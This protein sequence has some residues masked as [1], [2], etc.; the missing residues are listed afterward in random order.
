MADTNLVTTDDLTAL[1]VDFVNNF[2]TSIQDLMNVLSGV[3]PQAMPQGAQI[4]VYKKAVTKPT[5]RT[6]GEGEKINN[7]DASYKVDKTYTLAITDKLRK[8]TTFEAIQLAG[9]QRAIHDTDALVINQAQNNA[10][11]DLYDALDSKANSTASGATFQA[12]VANALGKL[13]S[14][15]G[16]HFGGGDIVVFANPVD[17][18]AWLGNQTIS[19]Q[20]TFGLQ[21]VKN[22]LGA[23]T[24]IMSPSVKA[25]HVYATYVKNIHFYYIDMNGQAGQLFHATTDASGLIGIMHDEDTSNLTYNTTAVGGWLIL[26]E[27]AEYIV[28]STI[29]ATASQ[30]VTTGTGK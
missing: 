13:I 26:P 30:P 23:N 19:V 7:I 9:A 15:A 1:S 25:G 27:F 16:D 18:Y 28:N 17:V 4:K 6:V 12:A 14:V 8:S 5:T 3:Y 22:F 21:Y 24:V 11:S 20:N 29:S 2:S 10:K